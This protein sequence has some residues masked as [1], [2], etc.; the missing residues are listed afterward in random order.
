MKQA[1]GVLALGSA[2]LGMVGCD[3]APNVQLFNATGRPLELGWARGSDAPTSVRLAPGG[4][5]RVANI[6][7]PKFRLNFDGCERRYELPFME[8]NEPWPT[9][10]ANGVPTYD[11]TRRY[12]YPLKVELTPDDAIYLLPNETKGVVPPAVLLGS[13]SH[14]YPLR[15]IS[16]ACR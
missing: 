12:E 5:T 8:L 15:P 10:D 14:G 6:Y 13:Q 3:T 4:S 9:R 1:L 2:L 16:K 11:P 7:G